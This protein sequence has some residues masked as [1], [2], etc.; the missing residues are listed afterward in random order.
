VK[1]KKPSRL[2][3]GLYFRGGAAQEQAA[4]RSPSLQMTPGY[5]YGGP[6]LIRHSAS[7]SQFS[8]S[9]YAGF[10]VRCWSS[11]DAFGTCIRSPQILPKS[12]SLSNRPYRLHV[13]IGSPVSVRFSSGTLLLP[14]S[15]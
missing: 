14:A 5:G 15:N 4:I 7:T 13:G 10:G 12:N 2:G 11:L 9:V 8:D 3:L 1:T 6:G